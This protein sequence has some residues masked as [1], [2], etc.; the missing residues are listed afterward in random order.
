[1]LFK[2]LGLFVLII[3]SHGYRLA[4]LSVDLRDAAGDMRSD[5]D[6]TT[7][8]IGIIHK[9]RLDKHGR[10]IGLDEYITP[11]PNGPFMRRRNVNSLLAQQV[12]S[13]A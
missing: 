13:K 11:H 3:S 9:F 7:A 1:M 12:L 2:W 10:Q 8:K 6:R 5:Q 4:V